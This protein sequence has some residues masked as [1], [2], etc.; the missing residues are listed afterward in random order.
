V[1]TGQLIVKHTRMLQPSPGMEPTRRQT[2]EPQERPQRNKFSG[3]IHGAQNPG[4]G[5]SVGQ[6]L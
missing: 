2:Q 6:A 4:L 1:Q 3:A 5:A